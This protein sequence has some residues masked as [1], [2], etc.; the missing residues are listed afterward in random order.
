MKIKT[1]NWDR[2]IWITKKDLS[3]AFVVGVMRADPADATSS[4]FPRN[5]DFVVSYVNGCVQGYFG[6]AQVKRTTPKEIVRWLEGLM[7]SNYAF[8]V[9]NE[10][11][12]ERSF[13]DLD[14][15]FQNM[16]CHLWEQAQ[17]KEELPC[18]KR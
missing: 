6:K 11:T 3:E 14:A 9:W 17:L 5:F 10:V 1:R 13:I 15:V 8:K 4:P 18:P 12:P 16:M 2:D 7:Q